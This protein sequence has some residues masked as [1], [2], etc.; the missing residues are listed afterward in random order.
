MRN[1]I[2]H[3]AIGAAN[4]AQGTNQLRDRL[5]VEVPSGGKHPAMSTHNCVTRIGDGHFLEVIAVDPEA[6][7]P[8]R[9][10]WFT[11]DDPVTQ[12]RLSVRPRALCWVVATDDLDGIVAN[13]PVDLGKILHL[14]RG[15]LT[16]R[17]TVPSDG[18]LLEGGL[19]PAFIEWSPGP[20]PSN[21]MQDLGLRLKSVRLAHPDPAGLRV[22]LEELN[23][24]HLA[25]VIEAS[26]PAL[27]FVVETP[28]GDTVELD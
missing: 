25:D 21:G 11:L 27:A 10:R 17:L 19:L 18:S 22:K 16:W 8:G 2:D 13:S 20:H 26:E 24:G 28:D 9:T 23:V 15:D 3:I 7:E 6:P 14:S 12:A 5:G 4:L 1:V